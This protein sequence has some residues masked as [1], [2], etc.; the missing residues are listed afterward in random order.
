MSRDFGSD[1]LVNGSTRGSSKNSRCSEKS[2]VP[3]DH[4][5]ARGGRLA[6]IGVMSSIFSSSIPRRHYREVHQIQLH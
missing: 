5:L 4:R 1:T 2:S 6:G 3:L